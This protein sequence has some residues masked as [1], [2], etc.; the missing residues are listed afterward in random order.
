[1]LSIFLS[2]CDV[3]WQ[4][5][6]ALSSPV[7]LPEPRRSRPPARL[8]AELLGPRLPRSSRRPAGRVFCITAQ[9][10]GT[11]SVSLCIPTVY[12]VLI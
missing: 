11:A 9:E 3:F 12:C 2:A 1:M 8:P 5:A 10:A 4:G 6:Q 7:F